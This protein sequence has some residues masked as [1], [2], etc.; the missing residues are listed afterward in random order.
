[1]LYLKDMT[2]VAAKGN[3]I[4]GAKEGYEPLHLERCRNIFAD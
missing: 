2:D 4:L 3:R 1:M